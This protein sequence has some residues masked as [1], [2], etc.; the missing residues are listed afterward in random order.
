[1]RGRHHFA[2]RCA[3]VVGGVGDAVRL[4]RQAAEE[5]SSTEVSRGTVARGF[6]PNGALSL[7]TRRLAAEARRAGDAA[8]FLETLRGLADLYC[9]GYEPEFGELFEE[10]PALVTLP[11]Y[12][13]TARRFWIDGGARPSPAEEGEPVAASRAPEP[14]PTPP[15]PAVAAGPLRLRPVKEV[16]A[17]L[18]AVSVVTE[19]TP[20]R[21][22]PSVTPPDPAPAAHTPRVPAPEV[23]LAPTADAAN[24]A[25]APPPRG[26]E[27][28][29]QVTP[30]PA[31]VEQA[32]AELIESLRQSLARALFSE[33]DEVDA[34]QSFTELGLDSIV[35]IEWIRT[36]NRE[37]GTDIGATKIYQY[38]T[39]R[40][41]ADF[42]LDEL[43]GTELGDDR[44]DRL[45]NDV[46]E[47]R[48]DVQGAE[49]LLSAPTG[50]E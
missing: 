26:T 25:T 21:I 43:G 8:Q 14:A 31:A 30:E 13:F 19:P 17:A 50:E 16:A 22:T 37:L 34:E 35:A 15:E 47:G 1:M 24:G 5:R 2:H 39:L 42:V 45:L 36:V 4:L 40:R 12:P 28:A 32:S 49:T 33:V 11:G 7:A 10:T 6:S 20:R 27:T 41:F 3:L 44:F 9:Q 29:E 23:P 46:Y 18:G 48:I 38:P